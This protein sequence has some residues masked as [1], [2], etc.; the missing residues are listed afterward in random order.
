MTPP[1]TFTG[2]VLDRAGDRRADDAWVAAQR[3]DPAAR[4]VVAS[5]EGVHVTR[6]AASRSSR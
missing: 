3:A 5:A 6:R 2:A 1:N 4:A